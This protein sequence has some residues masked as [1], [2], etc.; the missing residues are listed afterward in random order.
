MSPNKQSDTRND[1]NP[2]QHLQP[3]RSTG[4][5]NAYRRRFGRPRSYGG[6]RKVGRLNPAHARS[7]RRVDLTREDPPSTGCSA[8]LVFPKDDEPEVAD[9]ACVCEGDSSVG[10]PSV[11]AEKGLGDQESSDLWT[12]NTLTPNDQEVNIAGSRMQAGKTRPRPEKDTGRAPDIEQKVADRSR[13]R[14]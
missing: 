13:T 10:G 2:R 8:V 7:V 4:A 12:Y 11:E 14:P 9:G 5:I 3:R 6:E 1:D